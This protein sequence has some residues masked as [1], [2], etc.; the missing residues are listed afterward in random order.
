M[1]RW[2]IVLVEPLFAVLCVIIEC[3]DFDL[4]Y[5]VRI[6]IKK[7]IWKDAVLIFFQGSGV[8]VL[9]LGH[10]KVWV[11]LRKIRLTRSMHF[12]KFERLSPTKN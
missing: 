2:L 8:A 5:N 4:F 10:V 6:N 7:C 11:I 1:G 12:S 9:V 3:L